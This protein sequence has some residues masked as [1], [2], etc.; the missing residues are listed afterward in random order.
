MTAAERREALL[1]SMS[2][3]EVQVWAEQAPPL[4]PEQR[5]RLA[6]V[7]RPSRVAAA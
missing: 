3:P 5:R 6:Q 7:L 1:S 2:R 4:S